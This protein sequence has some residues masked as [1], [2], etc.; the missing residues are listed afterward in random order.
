MLKGNVRTALDFFIMYENEHPEMHE[1][2]NDPY[3]NVEYAELHLSK[4][5]CYKN[6]DSVKYANNAIREYGEARILYLM[7]L[8]NSTTCEKG[9]KRIY[10]RKLL[11]TSNDE[12]SL[13]YKNKEYFRCI[14]ACDKAIKSID[15]LQNMKEE[16]LRYNRIYCRLSKLELQLLLI[17]GGNDNDKKEYQ[18]SRKLY[19]NKWNAYF[20]EAQ[21][22][23]PKSDFDS[24]LIE[25]F[26]RIWEGFTCQKDDANFVYSVENFKKKIEYKF[27]NPTNMELAYSSWD[28]TEIRDAIS[29]TKDISDDN[30]VLLQ[31][32]VAHMISIRDRYNIK[33]LNSN[34][35]S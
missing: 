24:M 25:F 10:S 34:F 22:E 18:E 2:I 21:T 23:N 20:E 33:E 26:I 15:E 5:I 8:L 30:K 28:F 4:A 29:K 17:L 11:R 31:E 6:L 13:L 27:M 7:G 19:E 16:G 1:E 14:K 32:L 35:K 9:W 3:L 12:I